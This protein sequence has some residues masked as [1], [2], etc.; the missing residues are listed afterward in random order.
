MFYFLSIAYAQDTTWYT[1]IEPITHRICAQCHAEG[2]LGPGDWTSYENVSNSSNSAMIKG[3]LVSNLM[4]PPTANPACRTYHG[5]ENMYLNDEDRQL[6]IDWIDA[7]MPEGDEADS[8]NPEIP[9]FSLDN[10]DLEIQMSEAWTVEADALQDD[11]AYH[12]FVLEHNQTE[13][14]FINAIEMLPDSQFVHHS[15]LF[16]DPDGKPGS[17][18]FGTSGDELSF[19]CREPMKEPD[20]LFLHGW[21]PGVPP[22]EFPDGYG[23]SIPVASQPDGKLVLQIHYYIDPDQDPDTDQSRYKFR[24]S[25]TVETE[26]TLEALGPSGFTIPAN[27][28][29]HSETFSWKQADPPSKLEDYK[30]RRVEV[31]GLLPH[32][33]LYGEAYKAS[34]THADDSEDCL[35]GSEQWDYNNQVMYMFEEP[36]YLEAGSTLN[37]TCQW[38]NPTDIDVDFGDSTLQEMC[39]FLAYLNAEESTGCSCNS[40]TNPTGWIHLSWLAVL[41]FVRRKEY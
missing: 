4:P 11:N 1:D 12:C 41:A 21:A 32:M 19:D 8:S 29:T 15:L 3:Y 20:W 38:S 14:F 10:V 31:L 36:A 2:G 18:S 9:S 40:A 26:V 22:T 5:H 33:H 24:T 27:T 34:I 23:L 30:N 6:F 28:D 13:D 35:V 16:W 25:S 7:G 17:I 39:F 37:V